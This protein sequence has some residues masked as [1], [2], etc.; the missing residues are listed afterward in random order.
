[1][2]ASGGPSVTIAPAANCAVVDPTTVYWTTDS[3]V[4]S[5]PVGGGT[6]VTLA[7]V[8]AVGGPVLAVD[9]TSVYWV[10]A[11]TDAIMKLTPK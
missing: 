2:P 8:G 6:P 4:M 1:V 3:A 7:A 11:Q 9:A 10:S 5:E